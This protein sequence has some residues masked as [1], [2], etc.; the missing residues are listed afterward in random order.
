MSI[1]NKGQ[2]PFVI[3]FSN[4][5]K[6]LASTNYTIRGQGSSFRDRLFEIEFSDFYNEGHRP[7]DDFE[8]RF[9]DDWDDLEWNKFYNFMF[10]CAK[11][12]LSE[13]LIYP[14]NVNLQLRKL[15]DSS[16]REFVEFMDEQN[17]S[18]GEN[19]K[20]LYE[21]FQRAYPDFLNLRSNTFTKWIKNY[22]S[23]KGLKLYENRSN[24][25]TYI[26]IK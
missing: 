26:Y 14:I 9:F 11:I 22:C 21:R 8:R 19:K 18:E 15:I 20:T 24:G 23:L 10:E 3:P 17:L 25:K 4:S 7:I 1:E 5:P 13:G 12:Y 16:S 6:I 2:R